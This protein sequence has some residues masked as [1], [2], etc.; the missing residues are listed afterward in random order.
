MI[1][2]VST[3]TGALPRSRSTLGSHCGAARTSR[4]T[5]APST[6]STGTTVSSSSV[7]AA[8]T[9]NSVWA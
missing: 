7:C 8:V 3:R 1:G 9:Q 5:G 2:K 6:R 4:E